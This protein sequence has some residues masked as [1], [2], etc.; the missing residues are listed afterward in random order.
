MSSEFRGNLTSKGIYFRYAGA[1]ASL[2]A[3]IWLSLLIREGLIQGN[4]RALLWIPLFFFWIS[5]LQARQ[6]TCAFLAARGLQECPDGVCG[7]SPGD[8][9]AARRAA[10]S[11][12]ARAITWA[13]FTCALL[14]FLLGRV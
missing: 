13:S 11:L 1:L 9:P 2:S 10:F 5:F 7:L 3:S 14:L 12:V 8:C 4:L 6:K